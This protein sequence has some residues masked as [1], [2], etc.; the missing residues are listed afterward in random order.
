M[1]TSA[2]KSRTGPAWGIVVG[3]WAATGLGAQPEAPKATE[4]EIK[5]ACLFRFAN[6]VTWPPEAFPEL[7]TPLTIGILGKDPF[8]EVLDRIV[9]GETV[10]GR[11]FKI[12]RS[13]RLDAL[14]GCHIL[15]VGKSEADRLDKILDD[16]D[17]AHVLTVGESP[18]F[19]ERGGV[20]NFVLEENK[21]RFEF[22]PEAAKRAGIKIGSKL[23][24]LGKIVED[25]R[26]KRR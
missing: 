1:G 25:E 4:Y 13:S 8:G 16:L 11:K 18:R 14:K 22:N 10:G 20:V 17:G 24:S 7:E 9:E 5:A 21:V 19:A 6:F 3:L 26:G 12:L 23:L 2:I 15:F